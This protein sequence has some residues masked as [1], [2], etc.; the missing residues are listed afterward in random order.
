METAEKVR[1]NK[2]R[3]AVLRRGYRFTKSR[4]RDPMAA[5]YGR[6]RVETDDGLEASG[7]RSADGLGLTLDELAERL[8]GKGCGVYRLRA[9]DQTLLYVGSSYDPPGRWSVL[10]NNAW[11]ADV[12][13]RE[14]V[15]YATEEEGQAAEARA[16]VEE[17]PLHNVSLRSSDLTKVVAMRMTPQELAD[18]DA[19]RGQVSRAEWLRRILLGAEPR[20]SGKYSTATLPATAAAGCNVGDKLAAVRESAQSGD[21]LPAGP[22]SRASEAKPAD[23]PHRLP[24][25]AYCKTCQQSKP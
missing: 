20:L 7:F 5:G 12:R 15:W 4:L 17:H 10:S 22:L 8:G 18:L 1:E 9:A 6:I 2:L 3:R 25:G 11:W 13:Y 24:S 16:V 14:V 21:A 19:A 23:C